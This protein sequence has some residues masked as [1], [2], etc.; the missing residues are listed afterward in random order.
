MSDPERI[1]VRLRSHGRV[2]VLPAALLCGIAFGTTFALG[3]VEWPLWDLVILTLA[4]V[5]VV[6]LCVVPTLAWMSR[7]VVLTSRRV[8]VRSAFGGRK[9]DVPLARIHDVT[10][11]RQGIQALLGSGDVLLST[12]GDQ[13]VTLADVPS[14][15]LVQRTLTDLVAQTPSQ[16]RVEDARRL[17]DLA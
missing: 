14:A 12:G 2:L 17:E 3:R 16:P 4:L 9:R 6:T 1:V 7:R 8:I 13:P 15:S 11:R 10:L 5:L